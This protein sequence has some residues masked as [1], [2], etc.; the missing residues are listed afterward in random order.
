[1]ARYKRNSLAGSR[2]GYILNLA[3]DTGRCW[4]RSY[5][6]LAF[7]ETAKVSELMR[8]LQSLLGKVQSK[9]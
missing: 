9:Q 4:L 8:M 2:S 5:V 7:P 6:R 1:M 3:L